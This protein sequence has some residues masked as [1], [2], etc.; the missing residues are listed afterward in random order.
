[1]ALPGT[2]VH[3]LFPRNMHMR[4][5]PPATQQVMSPRRLAVRMAE[6]GAQAAQPAAAPQADPKGFYQGA[7][8]QPRLHPAMRFVRERMEYVQA[9]EE[10]WAE[11]ILVEERSNQEE[12]DQ[13][14]EMRARLAEEQFFYHFSHE[15]Q[16]QAR[17]WEHVEQASY[18]AQFR[19]YEHRVYQEAAQETLNMEAAAGQQFL[20]SRQ[21]PQQAEE[22]HTHHL[23]QE[24]R[25][26]ADGPEPNLPRRRVTQ[27]QAQYFLAAERQHH[28][29][30]LEEQSTRWQEALDLVTAGAERM[31]REM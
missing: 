5:K 17:M 28:R 4:G 20:A 11:R 27:A 18:Q 14:M 16:Q 8:D 19:N 23:C 22:E 10:F 26:F 6:A 7:P 31:H 21:E 30:A 25:R 15:A 12:A 2:P 9:E 1:M 29:A 3:D 24:A 13:I